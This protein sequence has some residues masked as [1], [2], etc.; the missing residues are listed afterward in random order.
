MT[1]TG[2]VYIGSP[3]PQMMLGERITAI[4][5]AIIILINMPV[6]PR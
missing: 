2:L 3:C 1:R 5:A 4:I 6:T